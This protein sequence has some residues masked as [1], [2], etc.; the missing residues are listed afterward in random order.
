MKLATK[1]AKNVKKHRG[2]MSHSAFARKIRIPKAVLHRL[3]TGE[4]N[5]TIATIERLCDALKCKPSDLLE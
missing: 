1:L 4:H 5:P 2:E 3:E